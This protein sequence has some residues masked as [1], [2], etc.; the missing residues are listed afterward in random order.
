L[1]E[2]IYDLIPSEDKIYIYENGTN[3]LITRLN[4]ITNI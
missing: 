2:F 4:F 1:N 3:K